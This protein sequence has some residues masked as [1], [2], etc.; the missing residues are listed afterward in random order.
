[1]VDGK[2]LMH[3]GEFMTLDT[4]RVRREANELAA[5]IQEALAERNRG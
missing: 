1:V 3:D 5:R 2:I 4:E